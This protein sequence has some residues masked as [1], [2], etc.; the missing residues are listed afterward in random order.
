MTTPTSRRCAYALST[1]FGLPDTPAATAVWVSST[2]SAAI[3]RSE[4]TKGRRFAR[5]FTAA[6]VAESAG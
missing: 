6:I 5:T 3:A 1:L 2:D 4:S